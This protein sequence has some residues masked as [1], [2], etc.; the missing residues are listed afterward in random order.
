MKKRFYRNVTTETGSDGHRVLL[1][2]RVVRSP[3]QREFGLP[4]EKLARAIAS[5]CTALRSL[6]RSPGSHSVP[7]LRRVATVCGGDRFE[8]VQKHD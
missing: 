3:A 1:D 6:V 4:T 5:E 2:G 7:R 8:F